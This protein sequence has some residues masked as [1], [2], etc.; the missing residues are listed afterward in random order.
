M[1]WSDAFM[2][3]ERELGNGWSL[4]KMDDENYENVY[5]L[6]TDPC[7]KNTHFWVSSFDNFRVKPSL[8]LC[9]IV[10][11][12][13]AGYTNICSVTVPRKQKRKTSDDAFGFI[14][15]IRM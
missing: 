10:G 4:I 3:C 2:F 5:S 13:G 1:S 8:E 15:R 6:L 14:C 7:F 9:P 11:P 12:N